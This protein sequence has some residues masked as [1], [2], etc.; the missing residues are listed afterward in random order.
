MPV[1]L[2]VPQLIPSAFGTAARRYGL[3]P[4]LADGGPPANR[5]GNIDWETAVPQQLYETN[6]APGLGTMVRK[7]ASSVLFPWSG[8]RVRDVS[9]L[10]LRMR[11]VDD[12]EQLLQNRL[13]WHVH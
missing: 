13:V 10:L 7:A 3:F 2:H 6:G 1:T 4:A 9:E 12:L 11:R 8:W 5:C